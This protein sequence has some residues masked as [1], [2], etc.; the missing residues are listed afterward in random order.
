MCLEM[1]L[2]EKKITRCKEHMMN[3]SEF[4]YLLN[5]AFKFLHLTIDEGT[6][7]DIFKKVDKDSDKK[8]TYCEYFQIIKNM[9]CENMPAKTS[10]PKKVWKSSFRHFLRG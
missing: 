8:I 5:N 10:H 7:L 3:S 1:A 9:F 4:H 6:C 2:V